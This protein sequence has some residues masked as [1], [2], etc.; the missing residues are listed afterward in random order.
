MST[1]RVLV[2]GAS[3]GIGAATVRLFREHGWDVVAVAR[4]ADRLQTLAEQTGADF[5]AAD[6][7]NQGDVDRLRDQL[8]SAGHLNA[9][10]NNAGG[11]F[12]MATV[13]KSDIA[14]W[15]K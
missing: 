14:D 8:D 13:E 2:T 9:V 7:T 12:G 5:F 11:A 1:R 4:R 15:Q 3:S 10:V 6:L